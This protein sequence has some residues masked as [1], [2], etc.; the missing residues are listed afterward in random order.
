MKTPVVLS[1]LVLALAATVNAQYQGPSN[2]ELAPP[3]AGTSG[4]DAALEAKLKSLEAKLKEA[5][6]ELAQRRAAEAA[7]VAPPAA[8]LKAV[9]KEYALDPVNKDLLPELRA[10]IKIYTAKAKS[11]RPASERHLLLV[12]PDVNPN[13]TIAVA[14]IDCEAKEDRGV[15]VVGG[16]YLAVETE[17]GVFYSDLSRPAS[18]DAPCEHFVAVGVVRKGR[19]SAV[20]ALRSLEVLPD[21]LA[22]AGLPK[23]DAETA[24]AS[25]GRVLAGQEQYEVYGNKNRLLATYPSKDGAGLKVFWPENTIQAANSGAPRWIGE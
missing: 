6:A 3:G 9:Q 14:T 11:K 1:A 25:A 7:A 5:Q 4:G 10:R 19:V 13:R 22:R 23:K 17:K 12:P 18:A 20:Q 2:D 24:S 16:R 8:L 15:R 21:A